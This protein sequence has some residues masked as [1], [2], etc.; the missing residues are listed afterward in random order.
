MIPSLIL[1]W[2]SSSAGRAPRSQCGGRG[3]DPLLLHQSPKPGNAPG[4][5]LAR[6]LY[7]GAGS[8]DQLTRDFGMYRRA[9]WLMNDVPAAR[10]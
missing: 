7:N 3:F 4:F 8:G 2:G 9:W 10:K 1:S 6:N 5:F